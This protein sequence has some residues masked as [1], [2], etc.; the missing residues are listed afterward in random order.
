MS[1]V[2]NQPVFVAQ[3]KIINL[4]IKILLICLKLWH[5]T[6]KGLRL[7]LERSYTWDSLVSFFYVFSAVLK[8]GH[9]PEG[10]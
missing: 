1:G 10:L 6:F 5:G 8:N 9:S 2:D 7:N 3:S 4:V